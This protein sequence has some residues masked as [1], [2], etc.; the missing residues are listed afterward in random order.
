MSSFIRIG[1]YI[2]LYYIKQISGGKAIVYQ[3]QN[4]FVDRADNGHNFLSFIYQGAARN[5]TGDNLTASIV[6]SSNR[7][8]ITLAKALLNRRHYAMVTTNQFDN[9]GNIARMLSREYWTISSVTYDSQTVELVL[10][11]AIDA[12]G[13]QAPNTTLTRDRVG[14]LPVTADIFVK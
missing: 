8:S 14:N 10:S 2:E 3:Y 7:I 11:S 5:R 6:L 4:A 12:V 9:A 13:A 1:Q